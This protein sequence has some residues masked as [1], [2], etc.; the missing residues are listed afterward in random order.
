MLWRA[1]G[2][3]HRVFAYIIGV[4]CVL[5]GIIVTSYL[6]A[7]R[8]AVID[9]R[10]MVVVFCV[11]FGAG[12]ALIGGAWLARWLFDQGRIRRQRIAELLD[13]AGEEHA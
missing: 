2:D 6:L 10:L 13:E 12:G 1:R 3:L 8:V 5:A 9:P 4:G 7:E 11:H